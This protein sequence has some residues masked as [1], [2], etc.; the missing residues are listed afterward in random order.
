MPTT[1]TT[2]PSQTMSPG[3]NF[4]SPSP[5][6]NSLQTGIPPPTVPNPGAQDLAAS[7]D[8]GLGTT[9]GGTAGPGMTTTTGVH[10]EQ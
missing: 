10:L 9:S 3:A 1:Q 5:G 6:S 8:P 4:G 7:P 2:V